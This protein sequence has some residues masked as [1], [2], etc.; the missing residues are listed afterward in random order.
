[1]T[2]WMFLKREKCHAP[3]RNPNRDSLIIQA[4]AQS[5]HQWSYHSSPRDKVKD[6][7]NHS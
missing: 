3:T 6:Q 2:V 1:V 4:M 7:M 5:Q